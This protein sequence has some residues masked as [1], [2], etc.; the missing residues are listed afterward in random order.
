MVCRGLNVLLL[1]DVRLCGQRPPAEAVF[2]A[3][4]QPEERRVSNNQDCCCVLWN[5]K[6]NTITLKQPNA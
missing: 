3:A 5:T 2:G 6:T 4:C 1:A